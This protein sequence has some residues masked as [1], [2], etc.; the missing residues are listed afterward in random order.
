MQKQL[1]EI[2]LDE[3]KTIFNEYM[4]LP[5]DPGWSN[6]FDSKASVGLK[7]CLADRE[8][9]RDEYEARGLML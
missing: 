2:Y 6:Y 1:P 5:N 9:E 7:K 4:N 3:Q 8:K